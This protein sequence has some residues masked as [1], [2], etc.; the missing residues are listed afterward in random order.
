MLQI[1]RTLYTIAPFFKNE[2][3]AYEKEWRL[4]FEYRPTAFQGYG[5]PS[6]RYADNQII[7]HGTVSFRKDEKRSSFNSKPTFCFPE[8][9][10]SPRLGRMP[11]VKEMIQDFLNGMF[12]GC[13]AIT[14]SKSPLA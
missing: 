3:F 11:R 7:P 13:D 10:L 4:V 1:L 12:I 6:F 9:V 5:K 8:I 14:N 2:S